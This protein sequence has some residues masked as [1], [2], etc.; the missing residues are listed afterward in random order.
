VNDRLWPGAGLGRPRPIASAAGV[1]PDPLTTPPH[2][3]PAFTLIGAP[4]SGHH[5]GKGV[6]MPVEM[7]TY[8]GIAERRLPG[9]W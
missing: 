8:A 3:N 1:T 9:R 6:I 7:L 5:P 4:W 2:V